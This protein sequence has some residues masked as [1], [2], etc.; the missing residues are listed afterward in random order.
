M[1]SL[2]YLVRAFMSSPTPR[3]TARQR[4]A[5]DRALSKERRESLTFAI[6]IVVLTPAL[7]SGAL[8]GLV[9][10]GFWSGLNPRILSHV[11]AQQL[12]LIL[13]IGLSIVLALFF[14]RRLVPSGA[15]VRRRAYPALWCLGALW[16]LTMGSSLAATRPWLF[17]TVYLLVTLA[18]LAFVGR[19]YEPFENYYIGIRTPHGLVYDHPLRLRDDFDR[20]HIVLGFAT[21]LPTAILNAYTEIFSTSWI[22]RGLTQ[23]ERRAALAFLVDLSTEV[24]GKAMLHLERDSATRVMQA[25]TEMDLLRF[26]RSGPVLSVDGLRLLGLDPMLYPNAA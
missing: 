24:P 9:F 8:V 2:A 23:A 6:L 7:L 19:G 5:F 17:W 4:H 21:A 13:T 16:A 12:A 14:L 22:W 26:P 18:V 25:L 20:S 10:I 11:N 1:S 15:R 3:P